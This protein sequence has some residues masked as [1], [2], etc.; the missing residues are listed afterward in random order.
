MKLLRKKY[1]A[2]RMDSRGFTLPEVMITIVILGILFA[3]ASSTWQ[4]VVEGRNVDSAANQLGADLRLANS[5][6]TNQL[7]EWRVVLVP[8]QGDESVGP[9]YYLVKMKPDGTVDSAATRQRTLPGSI[10]ITAVAG[11]EDT[12]LV[13]LYSSLGVASQTRTL[14]F[15]S[16]GSMSGLTAAAG[17]NTIEVT[18]DGNPARTITFNDATSRIKIA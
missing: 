6:A 13:S 12:G 1:V 10:K 4:S 18:V 15:N 9:D 7:A 5:K 14:K 11:L 3:I 2:L 17:Y 16:D 8:D